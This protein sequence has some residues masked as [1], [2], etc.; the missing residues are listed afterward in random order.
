MRAFGIAVVIVAAAIATPAVAQRGS[1]GWGINKEEPKKAPPPKQD[2]IFPTKV[3]WVA[4]S[5]NGK[6]FAGERP[7]FIIDEQFRMQGFGSCNNFSATAYPLREQR[8]A[9]GPFALTKKSCDKGRMDQERNFLVALRTSVQWDTV[10]GE[11]VIKSQNGELR[12]Q[13]SL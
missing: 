10:A 11:L 1:F 12:F 8:L 7:T 2:K 6:P 4:T 3:S 13:R 9:V 5:L